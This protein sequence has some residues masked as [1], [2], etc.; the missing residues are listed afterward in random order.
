[1][2]RRQKRGRL[3]QQKKPQQI[4]QNEQN[5]TKSWTYLIVYCS[6][7]EDT[8]P[9]NVSFAALQALLSLLNGLQLPL[10]SPWTKFNL[11]GRKK[12]T[13][14]FQ[15]SFLTS[16]HDEVAQKTGQTHNYATDIGMRAWWFLDKSS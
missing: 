11:L 1:M 10:D 8:F 3:V 13:K 12:A 15:L 7:N 9:S 2:L 16:K 6:S 14:T 5:A 4:K